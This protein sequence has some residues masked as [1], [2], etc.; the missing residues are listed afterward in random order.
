[1]AFKK[2]IKHHS[3]KISLDQVKEIRNTISTLSNRFWAEKLNVSNSA[4]SQLRSRKTWKH[5]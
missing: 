3:N 1:M 5:I 2:G 4:I